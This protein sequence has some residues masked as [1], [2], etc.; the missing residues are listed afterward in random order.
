MD[1]NTERMEYVCWWMIAAFLFLPPSTN[2][3]LVSVR[4]FNDISFIEAIFRNQ[5]M[6]VQCSAFIS[7]PADHRNRVQHLYLSLRYLHCQ[8]TQALA[9]L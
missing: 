4:D 5:F 3:A 8:L 9:N 2:L 7:T 6:G 1:V